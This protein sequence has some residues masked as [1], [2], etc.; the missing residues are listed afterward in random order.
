MNKE[1]KSYWF[2]H[3]E[4]KNCS[5]CPCNFLDGHQNYCKIL[6]KFDVNKDTD[7]PLA[8]VEECKFVGGTTSD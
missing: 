2:L 1:L 8:I 5:E 7:C 3:E 6:K 4:I